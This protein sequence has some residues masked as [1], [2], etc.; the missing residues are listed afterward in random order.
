MG[1]KEVEILL[2][3]YCLFPK[4]ELRGMD[5]IDYSFQGRTE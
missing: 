2:S 4:H 3:K 1:N 5:L